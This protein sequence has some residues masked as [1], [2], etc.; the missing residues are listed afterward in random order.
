MKRAYE[1]VSLENLWWVKPHSLSS[2]DDLKMTDEQVAIKEAMRKTW[3]AAD[4]RLR[5]SWV[6]H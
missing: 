4:G 1:P 6:K 2:R 5:L 3:K